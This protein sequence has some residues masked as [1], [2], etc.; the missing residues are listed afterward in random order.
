MR[1]LRDTWDWLR[2]YPTPWRR[3]IVKGD[4]ISR[5]GTLYLD[6][7]AT[8]TIEGSLI[9]EKGQDIHISVPPAADYGSAHRAKE[10]GK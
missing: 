6:C 10:G 9:V 8:V 7:G 4:V 3:V 2:S 1:L 5:G